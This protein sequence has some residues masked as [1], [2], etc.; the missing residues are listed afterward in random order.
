MPPRTDLTSA[1]RIWL[2]VAYEGIHAEPG[3]LPSLMIR[4]MLQTTGEGVDVEIHRLTATLWTRSK[5]LAVADGPAARAYAYP[6]AL[7]VAFP[8]TDAALS[9]VAA[10]VDGDTISLSIELHALIRGRW[11]PERASAI[12]PEFP[13][14]EW[15]FVFPGPASLTFDVPRSEWLTKVVGPLGRQTFVHLALALPDA[16]GSAYAAGVARVR[17]AER[18]YVLGDDASVLAHCRGA[19]EA[20]PG[21]PNGLVQGIENGRKR[22]EADRLVR[23]VGLFLH[24]GRHVDMAGDDVGDYPVD[25]R[26]ALLALN[27]TRLI[28]S[29]LAAL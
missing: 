19:I 27:M 11:N 6:T 3:P 29:Y 20:M 15:G 1:N 7:T 25:H 10:D 16:A 22:A 26:D 23:Q 13:N 17:D 28:I 21:Y 9:T 14:G 18:S 4:L 12:Q 2:S 5:R 8:I 24:L